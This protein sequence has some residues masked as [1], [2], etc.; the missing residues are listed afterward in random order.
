MRPGYVQKGY[1]RFVRVV[2]SGAFSRRDGTGDSMNTL[3]PGGIAL[4]VALPAELG[5]LR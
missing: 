1:L 3:P 2:A 5:G 4:L